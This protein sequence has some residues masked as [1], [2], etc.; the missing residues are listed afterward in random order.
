MSTPSDAERFR[1]TLSSMLYFNAEAGSEAD[2]EGPVGDGSPADPQAVDVHAGGPAVTGG[3]CSVRGGRAAV[4]C[5][6]GDRRDFLRRLSTFKPGTWFAK[7][8]A[9]GAVQCARRGWANVEADVLQCDACNARIVLRVPH[10]ATQEEAATMG[11]KVAARLDTAHKE[12]CAWRGQVCPISVARFP[13]LPE[14]QLRDEFNARRERLRALPSLPR[15]VAPAG[16]ALGGGAAAAMATPP[17]PGSFKRVAALVDAADDDTRNRAAAEAVVL[18]ALCGWNVHKV[19]YVVDPLGRRSKGAS[20]EAHP[21]VRKAAA[22]GE[23]AS[24]DGGVVL[25]CQLCGAKAAAWNFEEGECP[26][27][28]AATPRAITGPPAARDEPDLAAKKKA[29]ASGA[30]LMGAIGGGF[31]FSTGPVPAVA[32]ASPPPAGTE[33]AGAA[34]A[35]AAD[36][37]SLPLGFSIA[38]GATPGSK[39]KGAAPFGFGRGG[40]GATPPP[41]FGAGAVRSSPFAPPGGPSSASTPP[42][43]PPGGIGTGGETPS[44]AADAG[45]EG[46]TKK[47]SMRSPG[48]GDGGR[49][50][51]G[52]GVPPSFGSESGGKRKRDGGRSPAGVPPGVFHP[53]RQHRSHCPWVAVHADV[54]GP[55]RWTGPQSLGNGTLGVRP[56]WLCV[57]DAL[58]PDT[59]AYVDDDDVDA[60][61]EPPSSR[62]DEGA[63][64]GRGRGARDGLGDDGGSPGGAPRMDYSYMGARAVVSKY[65]A[66]SM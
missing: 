22:V 33:T 58:V 39:E 66:G 65:L 37:A 25:S 62:A 15:V 42:A 17:P 35:A 45:A 24:Q 36:V 14:H 31:G 30:A 4:G 51:G 9:V 61:G 12:E 47:H 5:R 29:R 59:G 40:V 52:G 26:R 46:E 60:A 18:L 57:L 16:A 50:G 28:A 53:L 55:G 63:G 64:E 56:G 32:A 3:A 48:G 1:A 8:A 43:G 20:A 6:P 44:N 19:P 13:R 54:G 2:G 7:P 49:S 21:P 34:V 41:A 27:T 38:G 23:A 11:A 10:G